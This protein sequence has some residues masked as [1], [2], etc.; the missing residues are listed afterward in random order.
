MPCWPSQ[1]L[2]EEGKAMLLFP[3]QA[4]IVP[5]LCCYDPSIMSTKWCESKSF[6]PAYS[7]GRGSQG[8]GAIL[9]PPPPPPSAHPAEGRFCGRECSIPKPES[10]LLSPG[11]AFFPLQKY[12][13]DFLINQRFCRSK[14]LTSH[15]LP[16]W[17]S[18]S[19]SANGVLV[20]SPRITVSNS[21]TLPTSDQLSPGWS[22]AGHSNKQY[23]SL[24]NETFPYHNCLLIKLSL[25]LEFNDPNLPEKEEKD[26][27]HQVVF[28]GLHRSLHLNELQ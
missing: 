18:P 24:P 19:A 9:I 5:S 1:L 16:L 17:V 26:N 13:T 15:P 6:T 20:L 23:L 22:L 7:I 2:S 28:L 12:V 27:F 11:L 10:S 3:F 4:C 14:K 21:D 8:A 25:P